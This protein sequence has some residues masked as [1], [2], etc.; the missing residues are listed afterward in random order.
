[1]RSSLLVV[2]EALLHLSG[3]GEEIGIAA[4]VHVD[5]VLAGHSTDEFVNS[6]SRN[7][8][9]EGISNFAVDDVEEDRETAVARVPLLVFNARGGASPGVADLRVFSRNEG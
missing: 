8:V 2:D 4:V 9:I 5:K 3:D 1:M 7:V 6:C